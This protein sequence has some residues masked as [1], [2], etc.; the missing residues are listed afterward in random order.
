MSPKEKDL[1]RLTYADGNAIQ[2]FLATAPLRAKMALRGESYASIRDAAALEGQSFSASQYSREEAYR[3]ARGR[4]LAELSF[5]EEKQA[6]IAGIAGSKEI[7]ET[8]GYP[9]S[10]Q[11]AEKYQIADLN[12]RLALM[13]EMKQQFFEEVFN[14]YQSADAEERMCLLQQLK[15]T[16][17]DDLIERL[18]SLPEAPPPQPRERE[19]PPERNYYDE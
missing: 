9:S 17:H 12:E 10:E 5:E 8:H 2:M 15:Q 19:N 3:F 13:Q 6:K 16:G 7:A 14:R 11:I 18:L 1:A 4:E